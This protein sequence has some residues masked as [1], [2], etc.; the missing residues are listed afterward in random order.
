MKKLFLL[1]CIASLIASCKDPY[2]RYTVEVHFIDGT[3]DTIVLPDCVTQHVGI[4]N[5]CLY[6]DRSARAA[7]CSVHYANI[8][9]CEIQ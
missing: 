8:L 1:F 5:G 2:Y 6:T 4:K 9:N 7:A 3:I